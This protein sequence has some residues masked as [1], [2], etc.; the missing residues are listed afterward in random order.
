MESDCGS[1]NWE[2]NSSVASIS[3][4]S[5]GKFLPASMK[6]ELLLYDKL[7]HKIFL[8]ITVRRKNTVSFDKFKNSF[9][10]RAKKF[11]SFVEKGKLVLFLNA[12]R[13][14]NTDWNKS[15]VPVSKLFF[16][17]EVKRALHDCSKPLKSPHS[18]IVVFNKKH[19]YSGRVTCV[20]DWSKILPKS[21]VFKVG[22][23]KEIFDYQGTV[24]DKQ[25]FF[26]ADSKFLK[27]STIQK[28][29]RIDIVENQSGSNVIGKK[30]IYGGFDM[31]TY[32]G[33]FNNENLLQD[34]KMQPTMM[35]WTL[36][37]KNNEMDD[38]LFRLFEFYYTELEKLQQDKKLFYTKSACLLT[39]NDCDEAH[40]YARFSFSVHAW[41]NVYSLQQTL[42]SDVLEVV[43]DGITQIESPCSLNF[44]I[45][46]WNSAKFD[47][48]M[49]FW[50]IQ[51]KIFR[52]QIRGLKTK[53]CLHKG[54]RLINYEI[55][56]LNHSLVF[57]DLMMIIPTIEGGKSLAN[58][59]EK[60]NIKCA[61]QDIYAKNVEQLFADQKLVIDN[62]NNPEKSEIVWKTIKKLEYYCMFDV[63]AVC[64][65]QK[66]FL[67]FFKTAFKNFGVAFV[68]DNIVECFSLPQIAIKTL[69]AIISHKLDIIE[70]ASTVDTDWFLRQA[71]YGGRCMTNSYGMEFSDMNRCRRMSDFTSMYPSCLINPYPVGA[72]IYEKDFSV[73]QK[74]FDDRTFYFMD[75]A[76]FTAHVQAWKH[77]SENA[78]TN[79]YPIAPFRSSEGLVWIPDGYNMHHFATCVDLYLLMLDGWNIKII[80]MI[81]WDRWERICRE[82]F[83]KFFNRRLE[84]KAE[85]DEII[86][87]FCKIMM[88]ATFGKTIQKPV[89]GGFKADDRI[90]QVVQDD[91]SNQ[92]ISV[93]IGSFVLSYSRLLWYSFVDWSF[94][95][96]YP[97]GRCP[98]LLYTDTDSF[99]MEY[100]TEEDADSH[101]ARDEI[102]TNLSDIID[103]NNKIVHKFGIVFEKKCKKSCPRNS[104]NIPELYIGGKKLYC[105]A[106]PE[107][108]SQSIKGKGLNISEMSIEMFK[109]LIENP[110]TPIVNSRKGCLKVTAFKKGSIVMNEYNSMSISGYDLD[111]KVVLRH[112][113]YQKLEY[114]DYYGSQIAVYKCHGRVVNAVFD[115]IADVDSEFLLG[116]DSEELFTEY[117][118]RLSIH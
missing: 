6:G 31:E 114:V 60:L 106:C 41:D 33:R 28:V 49:A 21:V 73:V 36:F 92:F 102:H 39:E 65:L 78:W 46:G 91:S 111:R 34:A 89:E 87:Y 29:K 7:T 35:S 82:A 88:N 118:T 30:C 52:S 62:I 20:T 18:V 68:E 38:Y 59:C 63:F 1:V 117:G 13:V 85:N 40:Q 105:M 72:L 23:L 67:N 80:E 103:E 10:A 83:Q 79:E 57:R 44:V 22:R 94:K 76:P 108:K 3:A 32:G 86:S 115:S 104:F 27:L 55:Q 61:K 42:L 26:N 25:F 43:I 50:P 98:R 48:I 107:C 77:R 15:L 56:I 54:P 109:Q 97:S 93:Q 58:F 2:E 110:D 70:V 9:N 53:C 74:H 81:K 116:A 96:N 84:A 71:I 17:N 90:K 101:F 5:A 113:D 4:S 112:P 37:S 8:R 24:F 11:Y 14:E 69:W 75:H 45:Y 19:A 47:S 16:D 99:L 51:R 100:W 95:L 12:C 64:E 66:W